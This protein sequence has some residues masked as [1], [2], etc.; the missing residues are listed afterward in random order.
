MED[1]ETRIPVEGRFNFNL[2]FES[3]SWRVSEIDHI[4]YF[5]SSNSCDLEPQVILPVCSNLLVLQN[6]RN[7]T[8]QS[9]GDHS[10]YIALTLLCSDWLGGGGRSALSVVIGWSVGGAVAVLVSALARPAVVISISVRTVSSG[11][12]WSAVLQCGVSSDGGQQRPQHGDQHQQPPA[13]PT[14]GKQSLT[15]CWGNHLST[16]KRGR[17]RVRRTCLVRSQI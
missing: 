3:K 10:L 6:A 12:T 9:N 4:S 17:V 7:F 16:L 2:T 8:Q 15:Y 11:L 13:G 1:Q 14:P 5:I